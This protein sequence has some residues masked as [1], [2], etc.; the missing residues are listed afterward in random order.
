MEVSEKPWSVH[1]FEANRP[2][3]TQFVNTRVVPLL[4]E[5]SETKKNKLLIHGQVKVG[6]REI[7]EYISVRDCE[8]STRFHV[9][10]SAFHR[11]ADEPQR[12]E[13]AA[14]GL[15]VFSI[16]SALCRDEAKCFIQEKLATDDSLIVVIHWDECDYGTGHR[17][18]LSDMYHTFKQDPRVFN[19]LYSATPE[20][21]LYS[22][23]LGYKNQDDGLI[24]DFYQKGVVIK[25]IPPEGY[26][27]AEKFLDEKLVKQALPWFEW[28]ENGI[29]LSE[30]AK[31]ILA[32]AEVYNYIVADEIKAAIDGRK[33]EIEEAKKNKDYKRAKKI[34]EEAAGHIKRRNIIILRL[35]YS[36]NNDDVEDCAH[37]DDEEN[38]TPAIYEF[39][40]ESQHVEDLENVHIIADKPDSKK[41]K[42]LDNLKS[43]T[44]QWSKR[45][46][47]DLLPTDKIVLI[48]HS[49]TSTRSTEWAC[50]DR[51]FAVHDY[52]KRR[53]FN[54]LAQAQLRA[55]HYSQNYG[56]TFQ[57][58]TIYGDVK[59]IEFAAGR[60][61]CAKYLR[62]EWVTRKIVDSHPVRYSIKHCEDTET[63]KT[64]MPP[65]NVMVAGEIVTY[66]GIPDEEGY[67][68]GIVKKII[69]KLGGSIVGG[70]KMSQRITI[71]SKKMTTRYSMYCSNDDEE[72][73][74]CYA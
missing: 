70:T 34:E 12:E 29:V 13:L 39:L 62:D 33:N 26:C 54:T 14:H 69:V 11:T 73:D 72:H 71:D 44:V 25:Y 65:V 2:H 9:F 50:H 35:S 60:I 52:R 8:T 64:P 68:A 6:K 1:Q 4:N 56:G 45:K 27:G 15:G 5:M 3:M 61:S 42:K 57:P 38:S 19:I 32:D 55:A 67:S 41:L 36:I 37:S 21:M 18:N 51:V 53:T 47:F 66:E 24:A 28:N 31:E 7:V 17:Q 23:E 40:K 48:V 10:I 30:Q 16:N 43:E 20:E 49:Q 63:H 46:Y 22:S 59:T 74:D 58:I